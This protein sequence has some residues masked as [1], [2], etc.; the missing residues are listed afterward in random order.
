MSENLSTMDQA[1]A[2]AVNQFEQLIDNLIEVRAA[3]VPA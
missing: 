2:S 3:P 1:L